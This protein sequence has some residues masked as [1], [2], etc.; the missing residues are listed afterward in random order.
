ML[1]QKATYIYTTRILHK[2]TYTDANKVKRRLELC[3]I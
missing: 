3:I 2:H 1:I